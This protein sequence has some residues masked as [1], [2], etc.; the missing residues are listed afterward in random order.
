MKVGGKCLSMISIY[1]LPDCLAV[2]RGG[3]GWEGACREVRGKGGDRMV[4][5]IQ[6]QTEQGRAR[7]GGRERA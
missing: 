7:E 5:V 2:G 1:L 6:R 4:A 3:G